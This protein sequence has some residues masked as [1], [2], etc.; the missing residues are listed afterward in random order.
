[1][2][3]KKIITQR[4]TRLKILSML[5]FIPDKPMLRLQY[6]IKTG[7]RLNLKN[8]RRFT[9]KIQWYK[10]NYKNPLLIQCVDKYDVREYVKS[11]GLSDIMIPCYGVFESP[12]EINWAEIPDEFVMK[13]TLGGGGN[14]VIIVRDKGKENIEELN[15]RAETWVKKDIRKKDSCREWPYYSGKNH[16]IIIEKYI[17]ADEAESGLIDYKFFCFDGKVE[18][19]YVMGDRSVGQSVKVTI[20]DRAFNKPPVRRVGDQEFPGVR[21]PENFDEMIKAAEK[22]AE[23]LP[24]VRVDLYNDKGKILF[25]EMTFY[26]A[27]GYMEYDPD[28]F[29]IEIGSK[30]KMSEVKCSNH[31]AFS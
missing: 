29:D 14:S 13:D 30:F 22:L 20:F 21:K 5:S 18:F 12:T 11:K 3:Y 17:Q 26:N 25:G 19:L 16:R 4:S 8:P 9:E 10:L 6:W 31:S 7:R 2:D 27:S 24:H 23:G 1:M 28:S 15:K